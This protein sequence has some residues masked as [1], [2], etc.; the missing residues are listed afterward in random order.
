VPQ[1]FYEQRNNPIAQ[2]FLNANSSVNPQ[3]IDILRLSTVAKKNLAKEQEILMNAADMVIETY[4]AESV[5]LRAERLLEAK[6]AEAAQVYVDIAQTFINDAAD[7][8]NKAGKEAI[9]SFAE[10]DEQ[11]VMLMGLKRF[12]KTQ[13]LNTRDARRRIAAKLIEENKYNF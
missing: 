10:G 2:K 3:Q 12:T 6:G 5:L 8:I 1:H 9:N 13:P 4:I 11:R 7:R